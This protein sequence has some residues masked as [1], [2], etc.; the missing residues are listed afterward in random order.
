MRSVPLY[1]LQSL[2]PVN[3]LDSQKVKQETVKMPH[4]SE[5]ARLEVLQYALD[6]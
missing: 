3:T 5:E 6:A 1:I 4:Y 2:D